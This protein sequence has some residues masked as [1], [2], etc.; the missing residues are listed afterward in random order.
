MTDASP[1]WYPDPGGS[2]SLRYWNGREWTGE[3]QPANPSSLAHFAGP[4]R[5][6]QRDVLVGWITAVFLPPV[7]AFIG[8]RL[9]KTEERKQAVWMIVLASVVFVLFI[10]GAITD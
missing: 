6:H 5:R 9:L 3:T 2:G 10:V 8:A 1:G 7:G 4:Q